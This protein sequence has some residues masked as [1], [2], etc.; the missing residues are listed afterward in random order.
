MMRYARQ[1]TL[2]QVMILACTLFIVSGCSVRQEF[3]PPSKDDEKFAPPKLDYS[4]TTHSGGSLFQ[5]NTDYSFFT[6]TRAYQVGDILTVSLD[7]ETKSEKEADTSYGKDSNLGFDVDIVSGGWTEDREGTLSGE[8]GFAGTASS[9][10]GNKLEG[11]IT[12]MVHDVLPNGA[13][14]VKGEKWL[15]LNQGEEYIRLT[16]IVRVEDIGNDNSVSSQRIA[17]ARI[18]YSGTG[19]LADSN[20]SGWLSQMFNSPWFPF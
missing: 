14:L 5:A 9:S 18:S 8:R 3:V 1:K 17:D 6:D 2:T 4:D 19:T 10:Q 7:E 13:L 11:A 15:I 20:A 12:V 16:G